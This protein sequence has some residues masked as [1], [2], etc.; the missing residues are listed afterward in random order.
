MSPRPPRMAVGDHTV[1]DSAPDPG[2]ACSA[3]ASPALLEEAPVA[4][5]S[6]KA[7]GRTSRSPSTLSQCSGSSGSRYPT[8]IDPIDTDV[9]LLSTVPLVATMRKPQPDSV[10]AENGAP[11]SAEH[12]VC[13]PIQMLRP[14]DRVAALS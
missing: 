14:V 11:L 6:G 1:P 4:D 10:P 13:A 2:T 5:A 7:A 12:V 9:L 8:T 3:P